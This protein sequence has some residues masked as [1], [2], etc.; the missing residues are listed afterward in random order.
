MELNFTIIIPHFNTPT[1]LLR[2]IKSIPERNDLELIIVDDNSDP[3]VV[4]FDN[5]PDADRKQVTIIR[6]S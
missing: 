6:N 3:T 2:L 4:D 1:L 5:F